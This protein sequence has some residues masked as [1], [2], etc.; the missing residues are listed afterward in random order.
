MHPFETL[1]N[2][3]T[4][5]ELKRLL[6]ELK[7]KKSDVCVRYRLLGEMWAISFKSIVLINEKGLV[8]KDEVDNKFTAI[9]NLSDIIQFEIDQPFQD[10]KPYNHYTVKLSKEF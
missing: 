8:L 6:I 7:E 1:L 9:S 10:I 3:I 4:V 5:L 2:S